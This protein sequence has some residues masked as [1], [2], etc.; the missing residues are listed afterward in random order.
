MFPLAPPG[1][2]TST[3]TQETPSSKRVNYEREM[4]GNFAD[5]GDFHT[6][7]GIFYMPQICDMGP[8]ALLSL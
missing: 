8:M 4:T 1:A 5:N 2:P 6:I 3:T 7:E